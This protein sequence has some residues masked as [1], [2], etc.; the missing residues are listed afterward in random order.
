MTSQP[1]GAGQERAD[2]QARAAVEEVGEPA[3]RRPPLHDRL[4]RHSSLPLD[5]P[6][7]EVQA[8]TQSL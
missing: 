4:S 3:A 7:I 8:W 5:Q 1:T 6:L 2:L